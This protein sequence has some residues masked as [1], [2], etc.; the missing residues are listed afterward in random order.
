MYDCV[1]VGGSLPGLA[2]GAMLARRGKRILLLE[3]KN[4]VGGR[5]APW[6]REGYSSLPGIPRVRYG[7]KGAFCRICRDLGWDPPLLSLNRTW[8]VGAAGGTRR[9]TLGKPGPL[10][11]EFLSLL[12][13]FYAWRLLR[14]LQA[15]RL[16]ELDEMS[17][18]DWFVRNRVRPSLQNLFQ[19]IACEAT[20]CSAPDRISAGETLR[21]FQKAYR[22]GTYLAYP[23]WGWLPVL[24]RFLEEIRKSGEVR[25]R[26]RAENVCVEQGKAV[27]VRVGG[28]LI[29]SR[30]VVC[31]IPCQQVFRILD[32]AA[33]TPEYVRLCSQAK[34][35]MGLTVDFALSR[36]VSRT[37][38]LW[39]FL[40]PPT[41]GVFVSNLCHRHAPVGRQLASFV[42]PCSAEE[43]RQ[44]EALQ[45]LEAKIEENFRRA[46]P[47]VEH[48]VEWKRAQVVRMLDSV[49][50]RADQ[51]RQDRPGYRVPLVE[52]LFLVSD[53]TC[54]PGVSWEIEFEA[55]LACLEKITDL[56]G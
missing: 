15:D 40:E 52:N 54:A 14:S 16:D 13:R 43:A 33:T 51:T 5:V 29:R 27:G 50:V 56:K 6:H 4:V 21:V 9:I 23:R 35:S 45:A 12:D 37:K 22:L 20:H 25:L 11:G 10:R 18:E 34:P 26:T 19:L 39:F 53:S 3:R 8:V 24:E 17:L 36:R 28:S 48:A 7:S 30:S 55:A 31:A 32:P 41:Y 1:I 46:C 44:P 42:C 47:A 38:G 2:L 49:A